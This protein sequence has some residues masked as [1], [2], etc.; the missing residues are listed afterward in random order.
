[1]RESILYGLLRI[2]SPIMRNIRV[3]QP[4]EYQ[5]GETLELSAGA[6]QH[7]SVVLRLRLQDKIIL[8]PG[9]NKVYP[10]TITRLEKKRV[11]V[12]IDAEQ[13]ENK[14]SPCAIHLMQGIAKSDRM[15]LI[16]QKAVELGVASITPIMTQHCALKYDQHH[17]P[18]KHQHWQGIIIAACEQS[19]RNHIPQLHPITSFHDA[20][21]KSPQNAWI[22]DPYAEQALKE[23]LK[24]CSEATLFIG[25]EGGFHEQEILTAERTDIHRA[26]LGPRILR[27]ETAAISAISILQAELGDL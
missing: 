6:S 3:Y 1:M 11:F 23:Q 25:P 13:I 12:S 9:N 26:T 19:G 24:P 2:N 4:G 17:A 10:A 8:F 21:L 22:L 20:I 15:D 5:V 16:I 14:E 7:V 18:K 27:T